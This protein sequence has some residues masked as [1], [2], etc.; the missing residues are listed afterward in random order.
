MNTCRMRGWSASQVRVE[1][2]VWLERLSV[3]TAS[4]P[5]GLACSTAASSCW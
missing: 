2:L 4:L 5:V 3:M 1:K